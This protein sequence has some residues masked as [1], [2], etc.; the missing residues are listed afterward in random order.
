MGYSIFTDSLNH[1]SKL[2]SPRPTGVGDTAQVK[3][4]LQNL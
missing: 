2:Q 4:S 3:W 1:A